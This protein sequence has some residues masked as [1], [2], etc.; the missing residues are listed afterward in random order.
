M[1]SVAMRWVA[2]RRA[3]LTTMVMSLTERIAGIQEASTWTTHDDEHDPEGVT[4]AFERAQVTGLLELA[5]HELLELDQAEAR[6]RDGT[7]GQCQHCGR[8]VSR[9]RLA[10]LPATTTCIRC[11]EHPRGRPAR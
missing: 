6:I 4:V 8:A 11:A 3:D 9:E 7:Y 10:A 5:R 1:D 2:E